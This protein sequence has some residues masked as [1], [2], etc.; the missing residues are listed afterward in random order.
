M[1]DENVVTTT[2]NTAQPYDDSELEV[3]A[4][5]GMDVADTPPSEDREQVEG[6]DTPKNETENVSET[7]AEA[8]STEG[9][10]SDER[11]SKP[12]ENVGKVL[13]ELG[14]QRKTM[15]DTLIKLAQRDE[16]SK[17]TVM[18]MVGKDK[19]LQQFFKKK[20]GDDYETAID[21]ASNTEQEA[22]LSESEIREQVKTELEVELV[23][24]ELA[25]NKRQTLEKFALSVGFNAEE[26]DQLQI[27]ADALEST[28]AEWEQALNDAALLVNQKKAVA[29]KTYI[30]VTSSG[31]LNSAQE[32][33]SEQGKVTP[34]L[35]EVRKRLYGNKVT[36]QQFA[37]NL[38]DVE[39]RITQGDRGESFKLS[40]DD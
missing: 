32:P 30:P 13:R 39:S 34:E 35:K 10:Q 12:S 16:A 24:K 29:K 1:S 15:G 23:K 25:A 27:K 8:A 18:D 11:S 21:K 7:A 6:E 26:V 19:Q 14:T 4:G 40:I 17:A 36:D 28:G 3:K 2:Q 22:T 9:T 20:Y 5:V 38:K 33:E 31:Q 37:D